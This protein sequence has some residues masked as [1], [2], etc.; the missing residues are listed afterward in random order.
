MFS[1]TEK[2]FTL[3]DVIAD[4]VAVISDGVNDDSINTVFYH[5]LTYRTYL[6]DSLGVGNAYFYASW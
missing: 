6:G 4:E 2:P 1:Y 3:F 5:L